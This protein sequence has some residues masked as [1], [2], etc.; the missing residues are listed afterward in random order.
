MGPIVTD[1]P[2]QTPR[3][4]EVAEAAL[5]PAR[6]PSTL[7][8]GSQL[9]TNHRHTAVHADLDMA[10]TDLKW[11]HRVRQLALY[12]HDATTYENHIDGRM[13]LIPMMLRSHR[14]RSFEM[15][16]LA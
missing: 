13:L 9:G 1:I 3:V 5:K 15:F 14:Q 8:A 2:D 6:A 11:H 4:V 12:N 16:A 7:R 10:A